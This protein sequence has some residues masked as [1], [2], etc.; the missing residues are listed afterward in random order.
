MDPEECL[1]LLKLQSSVRPD[2]Q[3]MSSSLNQQQQQQKR[4]KCAKQHEADTDLSMLS[5]VLDLKTG[6]IYFKCLQ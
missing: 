5:T 3:L 1:L 6:M 2:C 4:T